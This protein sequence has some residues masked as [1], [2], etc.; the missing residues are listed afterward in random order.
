MKV[1]YFLIS[2][3]PVSPEVSSSLSGPFFFAG[4][5]PILLSPRR[6]NVQ[7]SITEDSKSGALT[8]IICQAVSPA[9]LL[10]IETEH[11]EGKV[12]FKL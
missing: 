2:R 5:L 9:P 6:I 7:S 3:Y 12:C 4:T 1:N 11:M 10:R 8:G